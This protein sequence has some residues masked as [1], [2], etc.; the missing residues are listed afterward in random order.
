MSVYKKDLERTVAE[1][2]KGGIIVYPTDTIWG[3][4]C[5]A[6]NE[7]AVERIFKIKQRSK[8]RN[9]I[10]LLDTEEKLKHYVKE[11]PEIAKSVL[12]QV[13]TPLT[14]IFPSAYNVAKNVCANDGSVAIRITKDPFCNELCKLFNK[15]IVS[16]S[17]NISGY[18]YPLKFRDIDE[19]IIKKA[20]YV[21]E[22]GRDEIR[23]SKPSTIIRIKNNWEYE[24]V[25]D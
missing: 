7:K 16:T 17:A 9:L 25:R 1:L 21:V 14:I 10:I 23:Q 18:G 2:S 6:T 24:I 4:G 8:T 3:I 22:H 15:P 12:H 5:D 11:V 13:M 20:D 19:Y